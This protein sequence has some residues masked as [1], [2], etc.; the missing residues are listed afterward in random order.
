MTRAYE[1]GVYCVFSA[2]SDGTLFTL[3][4]SFKNKKQIMPDSNQ[5]RIGT[6]ENSQ[7]NKVTSIF[8]SLIF[9]YFYNYIVVI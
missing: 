9:S 7:L 2:D 4:V 6:S 5:L 3:S 1:Q 8:Y